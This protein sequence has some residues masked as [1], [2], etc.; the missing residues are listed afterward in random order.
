MF[1]KPAEAIHC[2]AKAQH[3][4]VSLHSVCTVESK[5][6][7]PSFITDM[8]L[9]PDSVLTLRDRISASG[10]MLLSHFGKLRPY[11]TGKATGSILVSL[12]L[13]NWIT[14]TPA[15]VDHGP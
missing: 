1:G 13:S 2:G 11:W 3:S 4:E 15:S 8:G 9:G 12:V 6:A 5:I 7:L 14:A 10:G